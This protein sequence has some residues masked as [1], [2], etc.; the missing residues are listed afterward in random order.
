MT[1]KAIIADRHE[2]ADES[3]RLHARARANARP[4]LNLCE[5]PNKRI[6]L[7]FAAVQIAGLDNANPYAKFNVTH[8]NVAKIRLIHDATPNRLNRGVKRNATSCPVSIDS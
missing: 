7:N 2:L 8:S 3:M 4:L 1:D 5:W 6:V